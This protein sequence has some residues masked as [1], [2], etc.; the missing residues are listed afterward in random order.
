MTSDERNKMITRDVNFIVQGAMSI[1][2][3]SNK[4]KVN[5]KNISEI[6][7]TLHDAKAIFDDLYDKAKPH[8]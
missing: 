6:N 5:I 7:C 2:A 3:L 1:Q 8:K 4:Q